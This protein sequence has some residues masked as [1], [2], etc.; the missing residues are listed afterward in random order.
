PL[1]E[2]FQ[3]HSHAAL[4]D[5]RVNFVVPEPSKVARLAWWFEEVEYRPTITW[6]SGFAASFGY[7]IRRRYHG[8]RAIRVAESIHG[9]KMGEAAGQLM[10]F[11][12]HLHPLPQL[13]IISAGLVQVGD[14]LGMCRLVD[15]GQ[16]DFFYRLRVEQ[17]GDAL[18][19]ESP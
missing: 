17:H 14:P 6:P 10:L 18:G 5:N 16:K 9:Q 2:C 8:V 11:Q 7:A 13:S 19:R 12:K 15:S 4:A 1:I 3:H